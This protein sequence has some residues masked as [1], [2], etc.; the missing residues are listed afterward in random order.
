VEHFITGLELAFGSCCGMIGFALVKWTLL[1]FY[2]GLVK[3]AV[4]VNTWG[5]AP[6]FMRRNGK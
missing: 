1:K 6:G 5:K 2:V 3:L 4:W